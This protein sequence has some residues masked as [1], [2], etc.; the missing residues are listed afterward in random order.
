MG[1]VSIG[2]LD[3]EGEDVL[4]LATKN[5]KVLCRLRRSSAGPS[6]GPSS[7]RMTASGIYFGLQALQN[8]YGYDSDLGD[9]SLKIR[10]VSVPLDQCVTATYPLAHLRSVTLEKDDGCTNVLTRARSRRSTSFPTPS[11]STAPSRISTTTAGQALMRSKHTLQLSKEVAD[12]QAE[13]SRCELAG[14]LKL[15]SIARGSNTSF[16][17]PPLALT[18]HVP[19][20]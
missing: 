4:L 17:L 15:E 10:N 6:P 13:L 7:T 11:P 8:L 3:A 1:I 19:I 16:C 9:N 12:L 18:V 20:E 14:S 2:D 5:T